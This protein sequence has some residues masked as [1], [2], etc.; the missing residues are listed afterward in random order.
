MPAVSDVVREVAETLEIDQPVVDLFARRLIDAYML[1]KSRGRAIAEADA[2]HVAWLVIA[3]LATEKSRDAPRVAQVY[4]AMPVMVDTKLLGHPWFTLTEP[5]PTFHDIITRMIEFE[6]SDEPRSRA[7]I[8]DIV[9]NRSWPE[10]TIRWPDG[11]EALFA[12]ADA[13]PR[14][15]KAMRVESRISELHLVTLGVRLSIFKQP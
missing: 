9:V 2:S 13:E 15:M 12:P 11:R 5:G 1:P 6:T 10:A 3:V 7:Y 8:G 14:A 4:G